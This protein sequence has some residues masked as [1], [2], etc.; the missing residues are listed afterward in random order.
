VVMGLY[1]SALVLQAAVLDG[2]AFDPFG[3][4]DGLAAAEVDIGR[5][6]VVQALG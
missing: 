6:Q 1:S 2:V 3:L 5:G 4:E